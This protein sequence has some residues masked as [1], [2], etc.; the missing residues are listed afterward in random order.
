MSGPGK[1]SRAWNFIRKHLKLLLDA[2]SCGDL[3]V[4]REALKDKRIILLLIAIAILLVSNTLLLALYI[5]TQGKLLRYSEVLS[6]L[7][8]KYELNKYNDVLSKGLLTIELS[9]TNIYLFVSSA[10]SY[11]L[12]A[13][14][15]GKNSE[16]SLNLINNTLENINLNIE[17]IDQVIKELSIISP[18]LNNTGDYEK[19]LENLTNLKACLILMRNTLESGINDFNQVTQILNTCSR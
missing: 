2:S 1:C 4:A 11:I 10:Y 14:L 9:K 3:R 15:L 18:P 17:E 7:N 16:L 19:I 8:A 6:E 5:D 13:Q 12:S